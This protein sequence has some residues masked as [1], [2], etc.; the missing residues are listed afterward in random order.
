VKWLRKI[1]WIIYAVLLLLYWSYHVTI[2]IDFLLNEEF[3]SDYRELLFYA[4]LLFSG[5]TIFV[6]SLYIQEVKIGTRMFWLSF[7]IF[8]VAWEITFNFALKPIIFDQPAEL[9]YL[10]LHRRIGLW[11]N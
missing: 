7:A 6:L 9:Y 3:S 5:V 10:I 11:I 4:D 1:H 2:G 8:Y